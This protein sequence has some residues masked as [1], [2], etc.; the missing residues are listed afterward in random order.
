MAQSTAQKKMPNTQKN[1]ATVGEYVTEKPPEKS[2]GLMFI[3]S[4]YFGHRV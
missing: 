4:Y 1:T 2:D 3:Y